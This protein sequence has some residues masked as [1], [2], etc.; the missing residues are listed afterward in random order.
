MVESMK[1]NES[2]N[3]Y[4]VKVLKMRSA[5]N[6]F[7]QSDGKVAFAAAEYAQKGN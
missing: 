5:Y 4:C 3:A 6:Q 2:L 1:V 7:K